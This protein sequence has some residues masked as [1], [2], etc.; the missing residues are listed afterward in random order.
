MNETRR[1]PT[2]QSLHNATNHRW[3]ARSRNIKPVASIEKL[4]WLQSVRPDEVLCVRVCVPACAVSCSGCVPV[5][6][7]RVA[8]RCCMIIQAETWTQAVE[9]IHTDTL[10]TA[11]WADSQDFGLFLCMRLH[12]LWGVYFTGLC[13]C[14]F[15]LVSKPFISKA[16]PGLFGSA[17]E[18]NL[19]MCSCFCS[20]RALFFCVY[21]CVWG[22]LLVR[23]CNHSI[24]AR[25]H[26]P[27]GYVLLMWVIHLMKGVVWGNASK[28][29]HRGSLLESNLHNYKAM[30]KDQTK[31]SLVIP[32]S[33][34]ELFRIFLN[35]PSWIHNIWVEGGSGSRSSLQYRDIDL[36]EGCT[37]Q[38]P[39]WLMGS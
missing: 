11:H 21:V 35:L 36:G 30:H 5:D 33:V 31:N 7:L 3:C 18:S 4:K 25:S 15:L 19:E 23:P 32:Q 34:L 2:Q 9:Q 38:M 28:Y 16:W 17:P 12:L 14:F 29:H 27:W 10:K 6:G 8:H 26:F 1:C 39:F 22:G 13:L 37:F 20:F 24:T